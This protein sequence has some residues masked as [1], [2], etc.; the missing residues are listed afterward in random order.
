MS[1]T[2]KKNTNRGNATKIAL[3]L[4]IVLIVVLCIFIYVKFIRKDNSS[5]NFTGLNAVIVDQLY[6]DY[7]NDNFLE[8]VSKDLEKYGFNVVIYK[9]EQVD[10]TLFKNLPSKNPKLL[11]IRAHSGISSK[12]GTIIDRTYIF[13]N[14]K[15]SSLKYPTEQLKEELLPA[16]TSETSQG[17][18]AIGPKF[19]TN[20]MKGNFHS[21]VVLMAGCTGLHID[22]LARAFIEKGA[23][24]YLSWDASVDLGYM[25][26]AVLNFIPHLINPKNKVKDAVE[27]TMKEIGP[28]KTYNA[29][30]KYYPPPAGDNTLRELITGE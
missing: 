2:K 22:D 10:V 14:E 6:S 7:P 5:N 20:V 13:T 26:E 23:M 8:T 3:P 12:E 27:T 29:F 11:I 15:Y 4:T 16:K 24:C 17:Y 21:T 28:D 9:G 25:D 19:I 18:F 1:K 30:L